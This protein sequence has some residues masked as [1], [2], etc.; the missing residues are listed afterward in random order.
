MME[1]LI[2]TILKRPYVVG[3]LI[4]YAVIAWR[5]AGPLWTVLFL[6]S[7]YTIA[8]ASEFLSIHYGFPYGW[9]HYIYENLT[10]EWLNHGVPVWDS[11]SYVFMSF[12]GL[13]AAAIA[14]R[15]PEH[16]TARQRLALVALA[17]VFVTLLDVVT[18]PVAHRGERWF[19]GKIYYYPK[20][21][22]YFDVTLA[23]FAGWLLT[24]F[25]INTLGEFVLRF[26][27]LVTARGAALTSRNIFLALGLYYGIFGF[28]LAIAV[29]LNEW[30]LAACDL[31]WL[32]V[33]IAL[34]KPKF[35]SCR[36]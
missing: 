30:W 22:F 34:L 13:C 6:L 17:T 21:G 18:D 33:T 5:W 20:P 14:L 36:I 28:A 7:G 19:L 35:G 10:G 32:G 9:Y 23:N 3:F 31:A 27:N 12:A 2:T 11:A 26:S 1:I 24:S 8:F 15:L 29:F 25:C 4:A 16:P